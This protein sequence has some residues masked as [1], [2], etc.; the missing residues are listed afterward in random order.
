MQNNELLVGTD[1]KGTKLYNP[2]TGQLT[3]YDFNVLNFDFSKSKVHA[4]EEDNKGNLW[5]GLYQRGVALVP[6]QTNGFI[7]IGYRSVT[8]NII[9]SN[10]VMSVYKDHEHM[11]WVGTDGDGLYKISPEGKQLAHYTSSKRSDAA[12]STIMSIYED[13]DKNLWIGSYSNGLAR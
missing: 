10:F 8:K 2:I 3:N 9:G 1:G 13:S 6:A 5:L 12:P 7:Y 4:I 11:L